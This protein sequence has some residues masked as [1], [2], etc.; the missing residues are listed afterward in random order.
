MLFILSDNN[1]CLVIVLAELTWST[2]FL[3]LEYTVEIAEIIETA[4]VAYLRNCSI[5]VNKHASS[6]TKSNVN[7]VV[8]EF[9][10]CV[11]LEKTAERAGTHA[12]NVSQLG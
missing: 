12:G 5:G 10:P 7:Y 9:M 1:S 2:P 8:G 6:I 11:S 3:T 4:I